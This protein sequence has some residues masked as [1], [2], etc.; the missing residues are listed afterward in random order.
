MEQLYI[1]RKLDT[2][3]RIGERCPY[4]EEDFCRIS[5]IEREMAGYIDKTCCY[6]NKWNKCSIYISQFFYDP[7]DNY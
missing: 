7:N 2:G 6:S 3:Q 1:D 5:G 4:L